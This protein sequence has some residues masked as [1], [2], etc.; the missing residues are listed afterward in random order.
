LVCFGVAAYR[1]YRYEAGTPT[2]ATVVRCESG[3]HKSGCYGTWNVS[4]QS[5]TG[6]IEGPSGPVGS[7]VDVHVGDSTAYAGSPVLAFTLSL[8]AM[9]ILAILFILFA[10]QLIRRWSRTG[11]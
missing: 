11:Q 5:R 9:V 7:T 3:T 6:P 10:F 2:S 1:F 4:G 8:A